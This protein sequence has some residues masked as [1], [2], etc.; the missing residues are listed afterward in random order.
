MHELLIH[1]HIYN[2]A[3]VLFGEVLARFQA[4]GQGGTLL[5]TIEP[6]VLNQRVTRIPVLAL[7]ALAESAQQ[8]H[9]MFLRTLNVRL[10][11]WV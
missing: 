6:Y 11:V 3:D 5:S 7:T 9:A 4:A 1:I 10:S 2:R 8:V